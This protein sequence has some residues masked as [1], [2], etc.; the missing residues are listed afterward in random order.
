METLTIKNL[1]EQERNRRVIEN[2]RDEVISLSDLVPSYTRKKLHLY[3]KRLLKEYELTP[4]A[5][6]HLL[7]LMGYPKSL[8]EQLPE[9]NVTEGLQYLASKGQ[10]VLIRLKDDNTVRCI[11]SNKYEV[12]NIVDLLESIHTNLQDEWDIVRYF[13]DGNVCMINFAHTK[14][15]D[16]TSSSD[17]VR[18]ML[19]FRTS[20]T[21]STATTG[22]N[23]VYVLVCTNGMRG[24]RP[25]DSFYI[26]HK[27]S[28]LDPAQKLQQL[29]LGSIESYNSL[30]SNYRSSS[31]E[32][33][34]DPNQ[35][36]QDISSD[37][38]LPKELTAKALVM[39]ENRQ[40]TRRDIAD[41]YT[42]YAHEFY[43]PS[44]LMYHKLEIVG[45]KVIMGYSPV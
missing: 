8:V 2:H 5:E 9:S 10:D 26:E 29:M 37:F 15:D 20:E 6:S 43:T 35:F 7:S 13:N 28:K 14:I 39:L 17:G 16:I 11:A 36:L 25:I 33:L 21:K 34:P 12:F 42:Q 30:V 27:K 19:V 23:S 24:Y 45:A 4:V 40:G 3:N 41:V 22:E 31:A 38:S 32:Y 1:I 44:Q 18:R